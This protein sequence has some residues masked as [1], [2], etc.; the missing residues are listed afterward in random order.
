MKKVLS[1]ALIMILMISGLFVLTGCEKKDGENGG[2]EPAK[3]T[4]KLTYDYTGTEVSLEVP[5]ESSY[6]EFTT[7][8]PENSIYFSGTFYL[9]GEPVN[10]AFGSDRLFGTD[11]TTFDEFAEYLQSDTYTGTYKIKEETK[12]GDRKALRMDYRYG[13]TSS[14]NLYGYSYLVDG[15]ETDPGLY[16][17]IDVV[18]SDFTLG[19]IAETMESEEVTDIL[20]SITF[21]K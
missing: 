3:A 15:G 2:S 11:V 10:I 19:D 8:E 7:E 16:Y 12:I 17:T 18:K 1:L 6:T 5:E 14:D 13:S 4:R 20:N 9:V 21:S